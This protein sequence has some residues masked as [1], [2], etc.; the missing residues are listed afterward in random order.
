MV[1]AGDPWVCMHNDDCQL[2]ACVELHMHMRL[3]SATLCTTCTV[4]Q[5]CVLQKCCCPMYVQM[6]L[7]GARCDVRSTHEYH[8][9]ETNM[10]LEFEPVHQSKVLNRE[11]CL[12]YAGQHMLPACCQD[13]AGLQT[14]P[15]PQQL[16]KIAKKTEHRLSTSSTSN[17]D[18]ALISILLTG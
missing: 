14:L 10:P 2:S 6:L 5:D 3:M 9:S 17:S 12:Y 16:Q 11:F 15:L 8:A 13:Y 7:Q 1:L 18:A 4:S